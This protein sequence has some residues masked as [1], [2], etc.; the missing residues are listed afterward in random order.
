MAG[1][2]AGGAGATAGEPGAGGGCCAAP[3]VNVIQ[4]AA[5]RIE[6]AHPARSVLINVVLLVEAYWC[7][8]RRGDNQHGAIDLERKRRQRPGC[9][10]ADNTPIGSRI[11]L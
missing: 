10:P 2:G 9:R 4:K 1:T 8:E 11:E 7:C 5:T 3:G 6:A